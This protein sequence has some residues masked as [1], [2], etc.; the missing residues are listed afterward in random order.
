[1]FRSNALMPEQDV[2]EL[3]NRKAHDSKVSEQF[4][5]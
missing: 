1:M 2:N 4:E 5:C 3:V